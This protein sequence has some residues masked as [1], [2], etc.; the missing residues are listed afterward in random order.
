[1][2][3]KKSLKT[4]LK[5]TS[6]Q[7]LSVSESW[8]QGCYIQQEYHTAWI[9]IRFHWIP[10]KL[11]G[12]TIGSR[13]FHHMWSQDLENSFFGPQI[14]FPLCGQHNN[15]NSDMKAKSKTKKCQNVV[16]SW[17]LIT[18]GH[19]RFYLN[20]KFGCRNFFFEVGLRA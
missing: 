6:Y 7:L 2:T 10:L 5:R 12:T 19:V 14:Y 9:Q 1:M 17:L 13:I 4:K 20:L 18:N 16:A 15:Q 8:V 3:L 11:G